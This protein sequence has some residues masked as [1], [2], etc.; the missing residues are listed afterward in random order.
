MHLMTLKHKCFTVRVL[1]FYQQVFFFFFLYYCCL[2]TSYSN[3]DMTLK[4]HLF[5]NNE[6]IRIHKKLSVAIVIEHNF[7]NLDYI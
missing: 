4:I 6:H 5:Y 7:R 3:M 1:F 2:E